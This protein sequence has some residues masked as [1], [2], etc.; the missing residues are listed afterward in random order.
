MGKVSKK[1]NHLGGAKR[2]NSKPREL[3][4]LGPQAI[5]RI[6]ESGGL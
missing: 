1:V 6:N 3:G 5:P 4:K 2:I